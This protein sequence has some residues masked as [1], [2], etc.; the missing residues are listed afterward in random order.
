MFVCFLVKIALCLCY[1]FFY[2]LCLSVYMVITDEY[3]DTPSQSTHSV[4]QFTWE[5]RKKYD[6]FGLH[7]STLY[8]LFDTGM[9]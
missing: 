3:T 8:V 9:A 4:S 6:G 5:I 7:G 1:V 2:D